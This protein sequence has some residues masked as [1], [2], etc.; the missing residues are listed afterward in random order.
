[1]GMAS[2]GVL[3]RHDPFGY[4]GIVMLSRRLFHIPLVCLLITGLLAGSASAGN[5]V[6]CVSADGGHSVLE[7]APTGDCSQDDCI[8]TTDGIA[9]PGFEAG[10]DDCGPCR[11][12]SSSHQWNVS[13]SR[14]GDLPVDSPADLFLVVRDIVTPLPERI[15]NTHRLVDPPPRIPAP[16]LQHRTTVL[17]I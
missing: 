15:L 14:Q 11:D 5:Y 10:S 13:R 12:I 16:I 4:G 8:P 7:F 17:L 2:L 3:R 6:W 1:M 9:A